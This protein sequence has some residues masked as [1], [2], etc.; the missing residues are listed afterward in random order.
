MQEIILFMQQHGTLSLALIVVLTLLILI[1]FVKQKNSGTRISSAQMTHLINHQNAMVVDV[2]NTDGYNSGHI[3]NSVSLPLAEMEDKIKKIEKFKSQ[4]IVL[5]CATGTESQRA[6]AV[7][8]KK[9]FTVYTLA[10]GL[11]TWKMDQLPLV[12]Q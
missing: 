5:V 9:G 3:I 6:A 11:R 8:Q 10:G 7:L 1:E 2:R 12:K 4:P